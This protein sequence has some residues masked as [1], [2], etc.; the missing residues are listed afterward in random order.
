MFLS[1]CALLLACACAVVASAAQLPSLAP[2]AD[3]ELQPAAATRQ[4][5]GRFIHLTD[6]HPDTFYAAGSLESGACHGGGKSKGDDEE[7]GERAG[8]WGTAIR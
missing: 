5:T 1:S 2:S 8:Y 4:L 6:M 3:G 7:E